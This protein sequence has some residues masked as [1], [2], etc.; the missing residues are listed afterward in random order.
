MKFLFEKH[1]VKLTD[2]EA[3]R[4]A[5]LWNRLAILQLFEEKFNIIEKYFKES[6]LEAVEYLIE[7]ANPEVC[8]YLLQNTEVKKQLLLNKHR[9]MYHLI[10]HERFEIIPTLLSHE[11]I[12][13]NI[14]IHPS[15]NLNIISRHEVAWMHPLPRTPFI[16][17]EPQDKYS[18]WGFN[19]ICWQFTPLKHLTPTWWDGY[20]KDTWITPF[21]LGEDL[22]N[23]IHQGHVVPMRSLV[24]I[25]TQHMLTSFE[26]RKAL[27]FCLMRGGTNIHSNSLEIPHLEEFNEHF[28][29]STQRISMLNKKFDKEE[30]PSKVK[31][32]YCLQRLGQFSEKMLQKNLSQQL[33]E[34]V[35]LALCSNEPLKKIIERSEQTKLNALGFFSSLFRLDKNDQHMK[36]PSYLKKIIFLK[37]IGITSDSS[38][39]AEVLD[40]DSVERILMKL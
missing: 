2:Y 9:L 19:G 12:D 16:V 7:K 22:F 6:T 18:I 11:V 29:D 26:A 4:L 25:L 14:K 23:E 37:S 30:N 1:N 27:I 21:N 36:I 13:L 15:C 10:Y 33:K 39:A 17:R 24:Y 40:N 8:S 28:E 31:F 32:S 20:R 35:E 5:I 38:A 3:V 34:Q